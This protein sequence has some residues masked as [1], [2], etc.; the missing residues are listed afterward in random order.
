MNRA[1]LLAIFAGGMLFGFGLTWS[2]M[3]KPE[4][5][6]SFL[7]FDDWGLMLVLGSALVT[8]LVC[9]QLAP[10]LLSKPVFEPKFGSHF[11]GGMSP[12]LVGA[13]IFGVGWGISG[14]CPGPAIAGLGQGNWPLLWCL[15]A[16]FAG[17]WC[18]GLYMSLT[19]PPAE[20]GNATS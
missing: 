10:K 9:Y 14:V 2:G 8:T 16:M 18:H 19:Q 13:A 6:L 17:S 5:V 20:P 12:T 7:R 1:S 15:L 3:T 4:V 11:S